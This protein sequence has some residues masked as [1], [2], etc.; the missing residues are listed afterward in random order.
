MPWCGQS[1]DEK[2]GIVYVPTKTAEPDF[3]GGNRHGANLFAN[4]LVALDA[5]TG[6]R[7]WHYQIVHHDLLDKDLP[8]PPVLLTVTHRGKKIDAV[9]QG[10]KHGL[11]FVFDRVTGEPIWPIEE[12]PVR[13]S[14]LRGE[15]TWP[16][17]PFPTRP[18]PLM[19][20]RYAEADASNIS[21]QAHTNTLDRIRASPNFGPFPAPSLR[22]TV[23]FPGFDGMGWGRRRSRRELLRQHQRDPLAHANGRNTPGRRH[24]RPAWRAGLHGLLCALSRPGSRGQRGG[25]ISFPYRRRQPKATRAI[26]THHP[27]GRRADARLRF[28]LRHSAQRHSGLRARRGPTF[29][30][31][32]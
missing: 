18:A 10:T 9:A 25:R 5:S 24:V 32:Y 2:R 27:T 7:L 16:T 21:P 28:A 29:R 4:S 6:K 26:V 19:R 12:N 11:L 8:C 23:M 3:Y 20:Q 13:P 15:Q 17:Q 1:L 14:D 31:A 30:V 22:E